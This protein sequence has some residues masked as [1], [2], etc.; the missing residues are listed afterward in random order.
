MSLNKKIEILIAFITVLFVKPAFSQEQENSNTY[1]IE[2][3]AIASTGKHAPFWLLSNNYG[4]FS[5]KSPS[6]WARIGLSGN[7]V[8][9]KTIRFN[10]GTDIVD[11]FNGQNK[12]LL[13]QAYAGTDIGPFTIRAGKYEEQFG[14]QD[15]SLSSGG[16]IWSGNS[17]PLPIISLVLSEYKS[18]PFTKK[19]VNFKGGISHGWFEKNQYTSN[20]WL[21]HKYLYVR[22]GGKLPVHFEYGLQ[23]FAMWGGNSSDTTYGELPKDFQTFVNVFFARG[24]CNNAPEPESNNVI[25]NHIGSHNLALDFNTNSLA[26]KFYWQTIFED[27]S[28]FKLRNIRD[29]LWGLKISSKS[30]KY[31]SNILVEFVNTTD[32][33]GRFHEQLVDS[34]LV[35]SGGNDNYFYNYIYLPG[36]EFKEMTI[37]TPLITSPALITHNS[38]PINNKVRAIHLGIEGKIN[39]VDYKALYTLSGNYGTNHHPFPERKV[40]HSILIKSTISH[41]LPNELSLSA[42]VAFDI[43][44]LYKN[45]LGLMISLK[46]EGV[47]S[48]LISNH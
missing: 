15:Q 31:F 23:H 6:I 48:S 28:G 42:A 24:G 41:L 17:N 14:N 43:G 34:N 12:F 32:Q 20:V 47:I 38:W 7:I 16:L 46:K 4:K 3:G 13:H 40:Q 5:V 35:V 10:Y 18:I 44:E 22:F 29:G 26:V 1:F 33:S 37:G 25:G 30:L 8:I 27:R 19:F 11:H 21:H 2:S 36:W 45:N 39:N 9:N